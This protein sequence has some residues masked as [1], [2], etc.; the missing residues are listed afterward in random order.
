MQGQ[1]SKLF[2]IPS[3]GS[4]RLFLDKYEKMT[5]EE[6]KEAEVEHLEQSFDTFPLEAVD[7]NNEWRVK[8]VKWVTELRSPLYIS[9]TPDFVEPELFF[10]VMNGYVPKVS[11]K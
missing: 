10:K 1:D 2:F 8:W 9:T 11:R 4:K 5:A 3:L 7:S 6:K